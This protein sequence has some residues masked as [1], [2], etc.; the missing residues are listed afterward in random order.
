[1][2]YVAAALDQALKA[3]GI[4]ISGVSLPSPD[5]ATWIVHFLPAATSAQQAQA[6]SVIA[7]FNPTTAI[8]PVKE[9]GFETDKMW[10][11][12]ILWLAQRFSITPAQAKTQ[13]LTIYRGL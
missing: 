2:E 5:P 13:L 7:S 8:V 6:Q 10:R 9:C 12:L 1:M 4:P 11:A 3:A